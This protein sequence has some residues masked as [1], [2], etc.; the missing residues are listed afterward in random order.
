MPSQI[1]WGNTRLQINWQMVPLIN[2]EAVKKMVCV[3]PLLVY[4]LSEG[5][6]APWKP[7]EM[8]WRSSRRNVITMLAQNIDKIYIVFN[9]M[10]S[11]IIS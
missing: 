7:G 5:L 10:L 6:W 8:F 2:N 4:T 3:Y 11:D 9:M 1:S